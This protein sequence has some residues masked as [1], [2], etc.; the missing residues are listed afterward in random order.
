MIQ[1]AVRDDDLNAYTKVHDIVDLY[2][3]IKGFPISFAVV[4]F[5]TDVLGGCPETKEQDPQT[6]GYKRRNC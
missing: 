2:S 5:I 4:P 1:L 6:F 3:P